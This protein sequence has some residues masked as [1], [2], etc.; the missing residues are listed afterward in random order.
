MK[1]PIQFAAFLCGCLFSSALLAAS[2]GPGQGFVFGP[3]DAWRLSPRVSIGAFWEN[4]ARNTHNNE[5][6]GAVG[7]SSLRFR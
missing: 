7:A 5:K 6:S 4:N 3:R 2:A 1:K